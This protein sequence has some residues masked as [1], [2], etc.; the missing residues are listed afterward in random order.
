MAQARL[1]IGADGGAVQAVFE[2]IN[3]LLAGQEALFGRVGGASEAAARAASSGFEAATKGAEAAAEA[4]EQ[5]QDGLDNV[6]RSASAVGSTFSLIAGGPVVA[7]R[8]AVSVVTTLVEKFGQF[9]ADSIAVFQDNVDGV[10]AWERSLDAAA[11]SL[12]RVAQLNREIARDSP[13]GEFGIQGAQRTLAPA[14]GDQ[15]GFEGATRLAV[16]IASA[17][18]QSL[19]SVAKTLADFQRS[20]QVD[21]SLLEIGLRGNE[22]DRFAEIS[23]LQEVLPDLEARLAEFQRSGVRDAESL[24]ELNATLRELRQARGV[25]GLDVRAEV[26]DLL[27]SRSAGAAAESAA[28]DPFQAVGE[29]LERFQYN[30]GQSLVEASL[31]LAQAQA[32]ALLRI[33]DALEAGSSFGDVLAELPGALGDLFSGSELEAQLGELLGGLGEIFIAAA[34]IFF[35]VGGEVARLI[36]LQVEDAIVKALRPLADALNITGSSEVESRLEANAREQGDVAIQALKALGDARDGGDDRA[37]AAIGEVSAI[38]GAEGGD[39]ARRRAIE[40][41]D[42]LLGTNFGATDI[43]AFRPEGIA[44]A[45]GRGINAAGRV[46]AGVEG[47]QR[48]VPEFAA[49]AFEEASART[50][51]AVAADPAGSGPLSSIAGEFRRYTQLIAQQAHAPREA[52]L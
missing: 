13:F 46:G 33:N 35:E 28:R 34:D 27:R 14:F 22:V 24:D 20:G 43:A 11:F 17:T 40:L 50:G 1:D 45:L 30:F 37:A 25:A 3:G 39:A 49:S 23:R 21:E 8:G 6:E 38:R 9:Q 5:I 10:R 41:S 32:D 2:T 36:G 15:G 42:D 44:R 4:V 48:S 29:E 7:L 52:T 12:E 18:N 51:G 26:F 31:P 47:L 19:D 16:D